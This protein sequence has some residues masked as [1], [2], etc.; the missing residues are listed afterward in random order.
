MRH[1]P[2]TPERRMLAERY[3]PLAVRRGL[4]WARRLD[5]PADDL[6]G[7]AE[8]GLCQAARATESGRSFDAYARPWVDGQIRN[9]IR[10]EARYRRL[11]AAMPADVE[12]PAER[13]GDHHPALLAL[14]ALPDPERTIIDRAC[15]A[16]QSLRQVGAALGLSASRCCELKARALGRLREALAP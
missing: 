14:A 8:L 15:I 6:I 13:D 12:A 7:A 11:F 9:E 3:R 1:D 2:L 4:D 10:R 5:R 16:G